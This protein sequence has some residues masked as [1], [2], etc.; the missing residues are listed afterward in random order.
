MI[1]AAL[2]RG[3]KQAGHKVS[4]ITAV[5]DARYAGKSQEGGIDVYAIQASYYEG[6]RA[7]KSLYNGFAVRRVKQILGEIKP[8]IVHAHNLHQYLSYA[9]L[10]AAKATGAKVFLT[11]HDVMLFHYGKLTEFIDP[12]NRL[13]FTANYKVFAW[14]FLRRYGLRYNPFRN[15]MIRRYLR[16]VDKI[17]AVSRALKDALDQ[18]GIKNVEVIHNG[19]DAHE[20]G[21][22]SRKIEEFKQSHNLQNKK[23]VLFGGRISGL[24]GG[25]QAM[26]ALLRIRKQIPNAVLLVVGKQNQY[27][28]DM[29]KL[30]KDLKIEESI[31]ATG[32]LSGSE[33]KLAYHASEVV[34]VP[35]LYL[36]PFPTVVLEAMA[37]KKPVVATCF[38][39]SPETVVDGETGYIVNPYNIESFAAKITDL[40]KNPAKAQAF[41]EAGYLRALESFSLNRMVEKYLEFYCE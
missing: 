9:C 15:I 33:L 18:N 11:A 32:W 4:V 27:L 29:Q 16:Y 22:D 23:V 2:A 31:I 37:C 36:D 5:R 41:G 12:K 3:L 38:G 30:A 26:R 7:Y 21:V 35:S 17:F 13:N 10:K 20:W 1:V 25:E 6:F 34:V 8:D 24:K 28:A 40:L 19:I 39:G 14:Q